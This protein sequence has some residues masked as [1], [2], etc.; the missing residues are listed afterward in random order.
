[1][2][3]TILFKEYNNESFPGIYQLE[4]IPII[5][6]PDFNKIESLS[7]QKINYGE[8]YENYY[9]PKEF[10]GKLLILE[11]IVEES[12]PYVYHKD[13]FNPR[14]IC[15]KGVDDHCIYEEYKYFI[16][17]KKQCVYGQCPKDY[18]QL[19][20]ECYKEGCP[21]KTIQ[22]TD[23]NICISEDNYFIINEYY[24]ILSSN[25]KFDEYIYQFNYTK[26]YLKSCHESIK[27]TIYEVNSYLYN[28]ICLVNCPENTIK[29]EEKEICSCKYYKYNTDENNYICY[30]ES[31]ICKDKIKVN[32]IKEC[33]D[34]K[35]ICINKGYKVFNN[36]CY[37]NGC[38]IN[39]LLDQ[40]N[41]N[42]CKC[43]NL[44]YTNSENMQ[45]CSNN[46]NCFKD[47]PFENT[48]TH[49]CL[50]NC[51]SNNLLNEE[52][53][54]N[55]ESLEENELKIITANIKDAINDTNIDINTNK[56]FK[57]NNIIY[58]IKSLEKN[59]FIDDISFI[60]FGKCGAKILENYH[61]DNFLILKYEI[62]QNEGLSSSVEY[63]VYHPETKQKLDL[64]ICNNLNINI[65]FPRK[66][67]QNTIDQY[68]EL[69]KYALV[70]I[71]N[72][73]PMR[74][75]IFVILNQKYVKIK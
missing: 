38:P 15:Y 19:N 6:E 35:N 74:I 60:D 29:D 33:E 23:T 12:C 72:I 1:M 57:G 40:N 50:K 13:R 44:F 52:C 17:D 24:K 63:E 71:I 68:N 16:E 21:S 70:N 8:P 42:Y 62:K 4:L 14:K 28:G 31:E 36:E 66:L 73:I 32:D 75:I 48:L 58:E 5:E 9:N 61:I 25:T 2:D 34:S 39:T 47:F 59:N 26:Q 53:I 51:E 7:D 27:Y 45:I 67:D 54:I 18:Y 69:K 55:N 65:Y 3:D 37:S 46:S 30:S 20:F 41:N 56:I 10:Y 11:Y 22:L 43:Q 64:S 49:E